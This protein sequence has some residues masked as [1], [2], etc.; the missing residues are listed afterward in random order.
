MS[1]QTN[2][3]ITITG[4]NVEVPEHFQERVAGKLAKIERLDPTLT[5][6][7]VE[8]MH[9][10]NPRRESEAERLQITATGKG[11]IA[12][13]EAKEDSFYA[14]L[15][16]ALSKMERSLRKVKVRRENVKSGHRAQKG[17]GEIAAEMVAE[18]EAAQLTKE[19][20]YIDPYAETVEDVRPGQI[21]RFKEHPATPMSVDDALS[22]MELVGHDFYLF[23]N[24]ENNKPSVVYRRHAYDYGLISLTEEN[25]ES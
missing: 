5:F 10:P 23:V 19:D 13:A 6:F 14:A 9:E 1:Q 11:H 18:A 25:E 22:E 3:Q 21:V 7:H 24:V 12:R 2:A 16:T 17:T 15:E 20:R 4:R 8:L